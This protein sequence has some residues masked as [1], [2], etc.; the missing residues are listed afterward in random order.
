MKP[1]DYSEWQVL[2]FPPGNTKIYRHKASLWEVRLGDT[3]DGEAWIIYDEKDLINC[4]QGFDTPEEAMSEL[5]FQVNLNASGKTIY[6]FVNSAIERGNPEGFE[7][8][9]IYRACMK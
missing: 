8:V 3:S 2:S 1:F 7:S 6:A 9:E 5:L 4:C